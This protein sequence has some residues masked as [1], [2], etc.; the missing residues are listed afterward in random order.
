MHK[1]SPDVS[2]DVPHIRRTLQQLDWQVIS[3]KT[4]N[5]NC[6]VMK[7]HVSDYSKVTIIPT[8][9]P[10]ANA[11][12]FFIQKLRERQWAGKSK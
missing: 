8:R 11:S 1:L 6:E 5:K 4:A 10:Q 12:G 3:G 2:Q 7:E 9:K